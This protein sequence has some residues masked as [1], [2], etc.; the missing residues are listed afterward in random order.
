M[1]MEFLIKELDKNYDLIDCKVKKDKIILTIQSTLVELECP[2]CRHKT[3][4]VH[5]YYTREIQDIPL[6]DKQTVLIV[7]GRKMFCQNPE[8]NHTTFSEQ[9]VF[10]EKNGRKTKRLEDKIL[11]TSSEL[12]S[13]RASKLLRENRI[14]VSKSTICEMLKKNATNCG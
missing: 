10:A 8:C 3:N 1:I 14:T 5:S 12:S 6:H 7:N 4:K 9:H 11:K 2:Y 13:V